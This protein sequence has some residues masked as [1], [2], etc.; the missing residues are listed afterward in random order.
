VLYR[1]MLRLAGA[2]T[3]FAVNESVLDFPDYDHD[4]LGLCFTALDTRVRDLL[5]TVLPSKCIAVPLQ[6][7]D[8][9]V[10]SASIVDE[11]YLTD[12]QFILSMSARI[13][14]DELIAKLPRLAK[15][16]SPNDLGRLVR[17]SLPGVVLRHLPAPPSSVAVKLDNQYFGLVQSGPVWDAIVQSRALSIFVPGEIADP[18]MELLIVLS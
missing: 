12:S 9:L 14:V 17:N 13:A 4:N 16:S 8:K 15:M 7:T 3:T 10:W 2:L 5:E 6:L 1:A 18:K 11:R